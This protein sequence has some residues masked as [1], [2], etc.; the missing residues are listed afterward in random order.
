M[1][2]SPTHD[3]ARQVKKAEAAGKNLPCAVVLGV[4]PV[5]TITGA[6]PLEY[7]QCEYKFSAAM[8]DMPLELTKALTCDLDVPA[9]AGFVLEGEIVAGERV[10]EGPFGEFPGSYSGIKK[11]LLIKYIP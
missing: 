3:I 4:D 11:Q 1:Q 8:N 5:L 9:N 2:G 6:T 7:N 10:V